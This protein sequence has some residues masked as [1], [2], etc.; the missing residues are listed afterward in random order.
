M[1]FILVCV[2]LVLRQTDVLNVS[3]AVHFN[4]LEIIEQKFIVF[5]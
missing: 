1:C 4:L 3:L 2:I 5:S